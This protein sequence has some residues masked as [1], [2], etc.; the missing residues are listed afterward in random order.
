MQGVEVA[1]LILLSIPEETYPKPSLVNSVKGSDRSLSYTT[2]LPVGPKYE[3]VVSHY[4]E[5]LE[6]LEKYA[7]HCH[8]YDKGGGS[9]VMN[10]G[11]HQWESLPN[12]G[13]EGHTYLHH[14][15]TNYH[16]LAD[17]T[18]FTQGSIQDHK[19]WVHRNI[20]QYV[21]ETSK[22]GFSVCRPF[23]MSNWGRIQHAGKWKRMVNEG[24]M[25]RANQTLGEF[26]E[27]V[28]GFPHPTL[29]IGSYHGIF[30]VA[31]NRILAH[32]KMF[33][34]NIMSYL[35]THINPEEGHYLERLWVSIF[36]G[37]QKTM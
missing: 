24:K 25:R 29:A 26:W 23:I 27:S 34:A 20:W 30:G 2:P 17:I 33:Y 4:K 22:K 5:N 37:A 6:W 11:F 3:F 36:N 14:I 1:D 13:R 12:V 18:V 31:K 16:H 32:P 21:E 15:I 35:N 28:F 9:A 10:V 7:D 19:D 8:V